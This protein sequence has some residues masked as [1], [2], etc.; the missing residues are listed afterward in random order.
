MADPLKPLMFT[1]GLIDKISGPAN[2]ATKSFNNLVADARSGFSHMA[3][4]AIGMAGAGTLLVHGA[5][6]PANSS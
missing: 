5:L 1:V 2:K 3:S 4:G 6:Q